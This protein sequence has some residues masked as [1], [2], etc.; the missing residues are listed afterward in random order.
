MTA[1]D[2]GGRRLIASGETIS[3]RDMAVMLRD[4]FP[5]RARRIPTRVLPVFVVR[6]LGLFDRQLRTLRS[7]LGVAPHANSAY[8]TDLTGV[9]FRPARESVVAAGQSLID[10]NV[11]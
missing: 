1:A 10:Y 5:S 3:M 4:A 7:D 8:V 11:I 2:T 9:A 6:L